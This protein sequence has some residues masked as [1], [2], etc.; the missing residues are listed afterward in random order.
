MRFN[1]RTEDYNK[2][3]GRKLPENY[4]FLISLF[5]VFL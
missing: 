3:L 4:N 1:I 5:G 2:K